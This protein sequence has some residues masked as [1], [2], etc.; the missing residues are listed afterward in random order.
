MRLGGE[1][2]GVQ[3]ATNYVGDTVAGIDQI[4]ESLL[5]K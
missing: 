1:V 4:S 5:L 3:L 2:V